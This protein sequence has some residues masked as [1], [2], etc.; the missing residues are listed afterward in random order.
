MVHMA[1]LLAQVLLEKGEHLGPAVHR[2]LLP[3]SPA[4]V[5]EER[6]AG[7]VVAVE[8]VVLAVL[9]ELFLMLVYLLRRGPLVVVAKQAQQRRIEVLGVVDG[10]DRLLRRE[11]LLG[12]DHAATP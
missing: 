8:L 3:V 12:L 11:L 9:L 1:A 2:L 4:I 10:R 6:V 5:I 7:A